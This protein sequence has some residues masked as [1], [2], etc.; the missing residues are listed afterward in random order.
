MAGVA[1]TERL[2]QSAYSEGATEAVYHRL[3]E[4]ARLALSAGHSVIV[5]AVHARPDERAALAT[6][7]TAVS[8]PF[9]GFWLEAPQSVLRDRVERRQGDAS[10][11][12]CRHRRTAK[13][14]TTSARS[15]GTASM[16]RKGL[17]QPS[18]RP[19]Q[20]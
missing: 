17:R 19:A 13:R 3:R 7:A 20:S 11:R 16:F 2:P 5:D 6:L 4:R 8:A 1:E 15:I 18:L 14:N 10:E 12:H 9:T